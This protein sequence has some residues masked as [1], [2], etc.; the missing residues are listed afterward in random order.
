MTFKPKDEVNLDTLFND[1]TYIYLDSINEDYCLISDKITGLEYI[2]PESKLIK[3]AYEESI[4]L[5]KVELK[6]IIND[7][8]LFFEIGKLVTPLD[9]SLSPYQFTY[10]IIGITMEGKVKLK[11][12]NTNK[13]C[14]KSVDLIKHHG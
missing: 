2:A 8:G 3:I 1:N 9:T 11:G 13:I 14:F 7:K 5:D 4:L 10:E 6:R 12:I